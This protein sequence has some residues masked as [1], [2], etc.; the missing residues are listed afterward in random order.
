MQLM[1][2]A[3]YHAD[4]ADREHPP[5]CR[6]GDR[7]ESPCEKAIPLALGDSWKAIAS[8]ATT[9]DYP[10]HYGAATATGRLWEK[11]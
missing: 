10:A 11:R 2:S 3:I 6:A 9:H 7:K 1:L 5:R 4:R 8:S